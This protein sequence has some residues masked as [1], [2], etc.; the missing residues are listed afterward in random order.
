MKAAIH[1]RTH[2]I[3]YSKELSRI[4]KSTQK[5]DSR[6]PGAAGKGNGIGW[7]R[8]G[9]NCCQVQDFF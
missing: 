8:M 2:I 6:L 9:S 5:V 1:N 7:E 4:S 3:C